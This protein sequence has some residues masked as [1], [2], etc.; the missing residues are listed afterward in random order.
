[1]TLCNSGIN[2]N[3]FSQWSS[4]N[5][6][7][8]ARVKLIVDD[9]KKSDSKFV[10]P[11][12]GPSDSDEYGAASLYGTTAPAPVG[13]SKYPSPESLRWD[14]PVYDDQQFNENKNENGTDE[15]DDEFAFANTCDDSTSFCEH[16]QLFING[17]S[18]GDVVQ[19][20]RNLEPYFF[21]LFINI[22][23]QGTTW[24][25]LVSGSSCCDGNKGASPS[26]VLLEIGF[27]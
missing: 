9:L 1:M 11:D 22:F 17:S 24:R 15:L 8:E 19:V 12:F 13:H 20:G 2:L 4:I 27:F 16:G 21:R 5:S 25:L 6:I 3:D 10:D 23:F 7:V 18:S 26:E 14:R